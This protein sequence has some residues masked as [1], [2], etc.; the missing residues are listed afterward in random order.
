[1]ELSK[2]VFHLRETAPQVSTVYGARTQVRRDNFPILE[3]ISLARLT[4]EA[5]GFREPHWHANANEL[6][7][8]LGGE[9]LVTVFADSNQ[10]SSFTISAGQMFFVPSG[11]LHAL[12]N[13]GDAQAEV[14]V[15]FS[16]EQ[17]QDFGLSGS[18]GILTPNVMGN[19]WGMSGDLLA[20][21]PKGP[22]D[23]FAGKVDGTPAV[24]DSANYPNE[25]KLDLEGMSPRVDN[26]YGKLKTARLD[27]WPVLDGLAM[28][29]LRIAGDGMREPHWHPVTAELGYVHT[30]HARM[31]VKSA[32]GTVDTYKLGPGDVYF[33][34][35][36]FPHHIENLGEDETH[37]LVFF[38]QPEVRD[39]GYSGGADAYPRRIL[40]PTLGMAA[41]E[42]P[43]LPAMPSDLLIVE[44]RNPVDP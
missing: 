33:I 20:G 16:D 8:C 42:F 5:G 6:G 21:L 29:S 2:H 44:K 14:I 9:L 13:I 26:A 28:Y 40:A 43:S 3:R 18:V 37:F 11:A 34:P 19:V 1:M 39:I 35:R 38:D 41:A 23:M 32:D 27:T 12:E 15:V 10:H 25:L 17:P 31:T 7:Y 22:E 36:A 4:V 30:G 24:P